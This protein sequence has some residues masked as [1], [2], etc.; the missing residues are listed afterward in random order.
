MSTSTAAH[1]DDS[2]RKS[3]AVRLGAVLL[4]VV[5]VTAAATSAGFSNDAW[6]S[7]NASSAGVQLQGKIDGETAYT[8]ADDSTVAI[9]VPETTFANMVPNETRSVKLDLHNDSTVAL[10]ITDDT[11]ASGDL[12]GSDS[13]TKVE[14]VNAPSVLAADADATVTLKITAGNWSDSLQNESA[15]DN[16]LTVNFTG[17]P[18][19][20][21][22]ND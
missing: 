14:L 17:T 21:S 19:A 3:R 12:L 8:D 16:T 9:E 2:H 7:A 22:D 6:F 11:V 15:D 18:I 10:N 13:G 1:R 4:A 5:G 20:D